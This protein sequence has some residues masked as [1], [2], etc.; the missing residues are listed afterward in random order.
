MTDLLVANWPMLNVLK[1]LNGL[2]NAFILTVI[3]VLAL[4][5]VSA[6]TAQAYTLMYSL[7]PDRAN[8]MPLDQAVIDGTVYG[9]ID[10]DS[11]LQQVRFLLMA[12]K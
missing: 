5:V 10:Q 1:R 7:S 12:L 3:L 6:S 8:A 11:G 9:F 4:M 2:C